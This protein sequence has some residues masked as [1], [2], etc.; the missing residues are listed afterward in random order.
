M[1]RQV[2]RPDSLLAYVLDFDFSLFDPTVS[3]HHLLT[4]TSGVADHLD[5]SVMKDYAEVWRARPMYTVRC[6]RD[7]LPLFQHQPMAYQPGEHST[8]SASGFTSPRVVA[9]SSWR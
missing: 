6:P 8:G 2:I 3:V 9:G 4:H 7:F 5:E 1:K